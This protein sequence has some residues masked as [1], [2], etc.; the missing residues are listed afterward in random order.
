MESL[1][2]NFQDMHHV[3]KCHEATLNSHA[4]IHT[5]SLTNVQPLPTLFLQLI[6]LAI[7]LILHTSYHECKF[8]CIKVCVNCSKKLNKLLTHY[9]IEDNPYYMYCDSQCTISGTFGSVDDSMHMHLF[10]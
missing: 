10:K 8:P 3:L 2:Q 5:P 1:Y 7:F 9:L 6:K 4:P